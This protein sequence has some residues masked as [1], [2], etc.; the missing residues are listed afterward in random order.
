[1]IKTKCSI[2]RNPISE[3]CDYKNRCPHNSTFRGFKRMKKVKQPDPKKHLYISLVKSGFRI[4]AG[5]A[6]VRGELITAGALLIFAELLGIAEEL[7]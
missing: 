4:G 2:C 5:I 3:D 6:L 7:V 1:M